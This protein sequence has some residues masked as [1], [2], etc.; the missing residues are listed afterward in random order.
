[1]LFIASKPPN[2]GT[3][4]LRAPLQK[5]RIPGLGGFGSARDVQRYGKLLGTGLAVWG[6]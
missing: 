3:S 2:P 4:L 6:L 1:M 5:G